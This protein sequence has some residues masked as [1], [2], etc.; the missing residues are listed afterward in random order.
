RRGGALVGSEGASL[1]GE[2]PH[3]PRD[4]PARDAGADH[5]R[6]RK[7]RPHREVRGREA[8]GDQ[9][10][11]G[12]EA[13]GGPEG[14]RR[15]AV[16]EEQGAVRGDG[17]ARRRRRDRRGGDRGGRGAGQGRRTAGCEPQDRRGIHHRARKPREDQ[18]YDDHSD[19]PRRRR[20]RGRL[21]D[22]SARPHAASRSSKGGLIACSI[23]KNQIGRLSVH[24]RKSRI[25]IL[26]A[27]VF[28]VVSGCGGGGGGGGGSSVPPG[29]GKMFI[30]GGTSGP[31]T[32]VIASYS[33]LSVP[34]TGALSATRTITGAATL[35][36]NPEGIA[37]DTQSD[38]LYV[39][40]PG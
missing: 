24:Q 39:A 15:G 6:E 19:Q 5:G 7:A 30:S 3:A 16:G 33:S 25:S 21:G 34:A 36:N 20:E 17:A 37:L 14:R 29:P 13:G 8:A 26:S 28:L 11:G 18:Q 12:G 32:S 31:G 2:E 35:L 1:R 9:P 10:R 38:R 40:N 27:V 22:D 23:S 4:H